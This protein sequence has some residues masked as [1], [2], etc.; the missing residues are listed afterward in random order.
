MTDRQHGHPSAIRQVAQASG[1]R[2]PV[3]DALRLQ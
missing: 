3:L 2:F 1:L